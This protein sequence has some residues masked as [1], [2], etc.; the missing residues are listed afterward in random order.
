MPRTDAD[1]FNHYATETTTRRVSVYDTETLTVDG[2]TV[3]L[4]HSSLVDWVFHEPHTADC[5][6]AFFHS[7]GTSGWGDPN[8]RAKAQTV[9]HYD[10][11]QNKTYE[12]TSVTVGKSYRATL[13]HKPTAEELA[14]IVAEY[15]AQVAAYDAAVARLA[16]VAAYTKQAP[17]QPL[18]AENAEVGQ[19]AWVHA[20]GQWRRGLVSKVG[21]SRVTVEYFVESTGSVTEKSGTAAKP[22]RSA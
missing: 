16:P 14:A 8:S 3:T 18:G 9:V 11:R 7:L 21:R 2:E 6:T 1:L 20:K 5:R 15:L 19:V 13:D 22:V 17:G 12:S 4:K 10:E